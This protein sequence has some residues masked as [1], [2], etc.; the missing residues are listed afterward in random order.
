MISISAVNAFL[1]L[2]MLIIY[3]IINIRQPTVTVGP[4]KNRE[5]GTRGPN[6]SNTGFNIYM[7]DDLGEQFL[8]ILA[9][10]YYESRVRVRNPLI[11][12]YDPWHRALEIMGHEIEVQAALVTYVDVKPSARRAAE[13]K[14]LTGYE[15]FEGFTQ[16]EIIAAMEAVSADAYDWFIKYQKT[17]EN[18]PLRQA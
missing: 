15:V 4:R 13:A 7:S 10:E 1:A 17:L 3:I 14:G 12:L 16:A 9:Q 18:M 8:P 5:N 11:S 2:G 6:A